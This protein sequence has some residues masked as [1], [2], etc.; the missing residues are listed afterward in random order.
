MIFDT[1]KL[2]SQQGDCKLNFAVDHFGLA[3]FTKE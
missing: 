3:V 1:T 2:L